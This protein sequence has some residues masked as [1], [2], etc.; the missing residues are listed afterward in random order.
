MDRKQH[1]SIPNV[2]NQT[3]NLWKRPI[4]IR[5]S[6]AKMLLIASVTQQRKRNMKS[7]DCLTLAIAVLR[8]QAELRSRKKSA[9]QMTH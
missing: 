7:F 8:A 6:K 1:F 4:A 3:F 9:A 5:Q 2:G